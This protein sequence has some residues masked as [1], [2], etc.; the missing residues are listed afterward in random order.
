MVRPGEVV[1]KKDGVL[2]VVFERPDAC[3]NCNGCISKK[4]TNV[5]LPGDAAVGD[6]VEVDLPDKNVVGASA[7][8]YL[9]PLAMLIAGLLL[10]TALHG[11]L[12]IG[13]S[14]DL[15]AAL[16]GGVCLGMGLLI[17]VGI[18]RVLRGRK[19]WQPRIVA[20]HP[21]QRPGEEG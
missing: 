4:C 11:T 6:E 2:T 3:G 1:E 17:V 14:S 20:V 19:D 21:A 9:I 18:D 12:G 7:I 15:F 8:A 13:M 5:E 10:G 16:A